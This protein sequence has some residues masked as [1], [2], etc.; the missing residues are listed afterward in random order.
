MRTIGYHGLVI[1]AV[2]RNSV[3][4]LGFFR[5]D[6]ILI[7]KHSST[8][9]HISLIWIIYFLSVLFLFTIGLN[10]MVG[11]IDNTHKKLEQFKD[12]NYQRNNAHLNLEC[13]QILQWF[14]WIKN[15]ET[16]VMSRCIARQQDKINIGH[17][18]EEEDIDRFVK[19]LNQELNNNDV[20]SR[21]KERLD[22]LLQLEK[23]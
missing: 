3:G 23:R 2:I 14:G 8:R 21:V 15:I 12:A 9:T 20:V 22:Q 5:Y 1:F 16:L 10:F 7:K 19:T 6:E 4:K 13:F 11:V 18:D 17:A